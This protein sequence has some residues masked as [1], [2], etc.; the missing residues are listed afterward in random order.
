MDL[1]NNYASGRCKDFILLLRIGGG[2]NSTTSE[3]LRSLKKDG[4][5]ISLI[6]FLYFIKLYCILFQINYIINFIFL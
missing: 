4:E 6:L 3:T 1:S 2:F 5:T